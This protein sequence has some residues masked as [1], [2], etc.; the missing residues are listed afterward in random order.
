MKRAWRLK[1]SAQPQCRNRVG[2]VLAHV[3]LFQPY[4]YG[5]TLYTLDLLAH[6]LL[7]P[8]LC[9]SLEGPFALCGKEHVYLVSGEPTVS[10][11]PKTTAGKCELR[12]APPVT[13]AGCWAE[14]KDRCFGAWNK[15]GGKGS[16]SLLKE[17]L[18]AWRSLVLRWDVHLGQHMQKLAESHENSSLFRSEQKV[19]ID[20]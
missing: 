13:L 5:T 8:G 14:I 11:M 6:Q 9:L 19:Q 2:V 20:L 15:Q 7:G 4:R 17:W 1:S 18:R 10:S 12:A 16:C 3:H